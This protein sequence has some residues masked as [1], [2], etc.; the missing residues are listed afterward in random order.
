[1]K[2]RRGIRARFTRGA[3]TLR[4]HFPVCHTSLC[5]WLHGVV[6]LPRL[7]LEVLVPRADLEVT[8]RTVFL[9]VG[10]RVADRILAAHLFLELVE[11]VLQG[12]F[13]IDAEH[14]SAS[15]FGHLPQRGIADP[16]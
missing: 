8:E 16:A 7:H 14:T 10:R 2:P 13:A 1:M 11:D 6:A 15:L 9:L 3:F 4:R 12:V 5:G